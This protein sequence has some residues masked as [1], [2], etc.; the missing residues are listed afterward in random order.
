MAG[1][2]SK[3]PVRR[4]EETIAQGYA[5][6]DAD[7]NAAAL[8]T[9][10]V[11][12]GRPSVRTVYVHIRYEEIVFFVNSYSGKGQQLQWNPYAA[13]CFFWRYMQQQVTVD[14]LVEVL[15]DAVADDYWSRRSRESTLGSHASRQHLHEGDEAGLKARL[16]EEKQRFSFTK[17]NRPAHWI[18]YRLIPDRLE[19]W[20]TGWGRLRAREL[21]ECDMERHWTRLTQEP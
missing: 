7:A 9:S 19:F 20:D 6:D 12:S 16:H 4:L 15:D 8:A 21:F 13:L 14:G 5:R 10:D 11:T 3:N 2:E 1:S 18:G 17:S